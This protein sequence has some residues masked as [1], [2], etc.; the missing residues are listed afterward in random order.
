MPGHSTVYQLI[1]LYHKICLALEDHKH[2]CM[3]FCDI[4]K[5]FDRVWHKGLILKLE[6]YGISGELL[7]WLK[8]Y[9]S[10]RKQQVFIEDSVSISQ[11]IKAGVPQGSVLGPLLFL[12]YINDIANI[13]QSSARLFA[14]DTS[15]LFSS[16]SCLDIQNVLNNDLKMLNDW[17]KRWLVTFNSDKTKV[18]F[19]SNFDDIDEELELRFNNE[20]LDFVDSHRHLGV[21]FSSDGKWNKH[22]SSIH[23]SVMKKIN[24]L[25][26]LKFLLSRESLLQIYKTFILPVLEYACE[27]WDG[28]SDSDSDLLEKAQLEAARIITGL[29][30][31]SSRNS[32]YFESGLEPLHSRRKRRKLNLL[33]K[34]HNGQTPQYLTSLL[35]ETVGDRVNYALRNNHDFDI[36]RFRL[37]SSN[38]S[39]LPSVIRYWNELNL[40]TRSLP[41]LNEFRKA[42][43]PEN[44]KAPKFYSVGDRKTNIV[45]TKLRNTCSSLKYDLF[46]VN[47]IDSPDC[48]C[49]NACENACHFLLECSRFNVQRSE[50]LH[51]LEI[52]DVMIDV[53]L[54]LYGSENLSVDNNSKIFEIVMH[55]IKT[56]HR[57]D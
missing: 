17:A 8:D 24:A 41:T 43:Y 31:F 53:N 19:I 44:E 16:H 3:I 25:R 11:P 14:D 26:S 33:Y 1:E 48:I 37:S 52:Y 12:I 7:S 45:N 47:I 23:E 46:R 50:M 2:T 15:L 6:S 13:F 39:F 32:L 27:V 55:Y 20:I 29:P 34:M 28:C 30:S 9:I 49:G 38:L 36:P 40:E 51:S 10:N 4:S 18:I 21:I 56:T 57:F 54:L 35:P 5:A 22:I 42:I